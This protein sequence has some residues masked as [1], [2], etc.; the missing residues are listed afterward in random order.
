MHADPDGQPRPTTAPPRTGGGPRALRRVRRWYR[1]TPQGQVVS[2]VVVLVIVLA[3]AVV[4]A[5]VAVTG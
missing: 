3:V 2:T 1:R 4:G 5:Y